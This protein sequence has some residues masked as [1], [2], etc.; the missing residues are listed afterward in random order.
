MITVDM[1]LGISAPTPGAHQI[2]PSGC[3]EVLER[4]Q[5]V[6]EALRGEEEV[7]LLDLSKATGINKNLLHTD[8]L[9]LSGI[10]LVRT[11]TINRRR[12]WSAA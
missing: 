2:A 1:L 8:L 10:G 4:R 3:P 6:V 7:R 11:K 9:H 5:Q 12:V